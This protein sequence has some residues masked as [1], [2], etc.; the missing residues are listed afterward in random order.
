MAINDTGLIARWYL[1]EAASGVGDSF[2]FDTTD[3]NIDLTLNYDAGATDLEWTEV[4][5]NRGLEFKDSNSVAMAAYELVENGEPLFDTFEGASIITLEVVAALTSGSGSTGR[6]AAFNYATSNAEIGFNM[7]GT[8]A[9]IFV[10]EVLCRS[11]TVDT[12]RHVYHVVIDTTETTANDRVKLYVDGTIASPTI[13]ANPTLDAAFDLTDNTDF[14]IGNRGGGGGRSIVGDVYYVAL[15]NVA[16]S[17]T[18]ITNNDSVLSASDDTP[19]AGD[20]TYL[21]FGDSLNI[22]GEAAATIGFTYTPLGDGLT[23][24]GIA[25]TSN[26]I[27]NI[28]VISFISPTSSGTQDITFSGFGTPTAAIVIGIESENSSVETF[29]SVYDGLGINVGFSDGINDRQA[30]MVSTHAAATSQS[31]RTMQAAVIEQHNQTGSP[32]SLL[33][34]ATSEFITDGIRLTWAGAPVAHRYSVTLFIGTDNVAVGDAI[35]IASND[36]GFRPSVI[37]AATTGTNYPDTVVAAV[38]SIGCVLDD[39]SNT[40]RAIHMSDEVDRPTMANNIYVDTSESIGQAYS[41]SLSWSGN[42]TIDNDGFDTSNLDVDEMIY[43]AIDLPS[44]ISTALDTYAT[45]TST[46]GDTITGLG[47]EPGFVFLP[48]SNAA[49]IDT[50]NSTNVFGFQFGMADGTNEFSFNIATEDNIED[51]NTQSKATES[52]VDL[53]YDDGTQLVA[54]TLASFDADGFTVDYTTVD[55][56]ARYGWYLAMETEVEAT[57]EFTYTPLGD[58][59]NINGTASSEATAD[60]TYTSLGD[61]LNINGEATT[62]SSIGSVYTSIGTLTLNGFST[63]EVTADF[64]YSADDT[65][66]IEGSSATEQTVEHE[67]T[68]EGTLT[69]DGFSSTETTSDYTY[70]SLGEEL[71]IDGLAYTTSAYEVEYIPTGTLTLDGIGTLEISDLNFVFTANEGLILSGTSASDHTES[72]IYI[73]EGFA[74]LSG[75]SETTFSNNFIQLPIGK[76]LLS[77]SSDSNFTRIFSYNPAGE[78]IFDGYSATTFSLGNVYAAGGSLLFDGIAVTELLIENWIFSPTGFIQLNGIP[79]YEAGDVEFIYF[80][81]DLTLIFNGTVPVDD[82]FGRE[83]IPVYFPSEGDSDEFGITT[84]E[85][86]FFE[87]KFNF[88]EFFRER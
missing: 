43:L 76:I 23:V 73:S 78:F 64:I 24:D 18:N 48:L 16:M 88:A 13:D 17:T 62:T 72:F 2:A 8:S 14:F 1:D 33:A 4:S 34:S 45:P 49:T 37:F 65:L 59:L 42:I 41:S 19:T 26:K 36:L 66:V 56:S 63:T 61:S 83:L 30:S 44:G 86:I 50:I 51:S 28:K 32:F 5:G 85:R 40:E 15:Y 7:T 80:P 27:F 3:N 82:F 77:G 53:P 25:N 58:S 20:F 12:A 71:L 79:S 39:G 47:F 70:V 60:Y 68:I 81:K 57:A 38:L 69:L 10:N 22:N 11:W 67:Y 46:G 75:F 29:G 87:N 52:L 6:V 9:E 84:T 35:G 54:G 31:S 21:P 74:A 55:G